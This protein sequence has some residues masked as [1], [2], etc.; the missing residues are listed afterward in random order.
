MENL[1]LVFSLLSAVAAAL[2]AIFGKI[3]LQAVD[4]NAATA[5]RAAIM[6]VFLFLV[7]TVQGSYQQVLALFND[8]KALLF[9]ALSGIAGASSWLFYFLALK[10]GK[11]AQVAPIDKLS[12]VL[13]VIFAVVFLGE[14]VAFWNGV[15]IAF[16]AVGA[17]I[18][19][20]S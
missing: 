20:L 16:I 11:V 6:T 5:L 13:A 4:A 17:I 1:W 3:G 9:I 15:G 8:K 19:A 18:V 7:V 12:V 14:K 2:V 10:F